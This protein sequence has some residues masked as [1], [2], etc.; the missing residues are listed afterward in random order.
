M[1]QVAKT[2]QLIEEFSPYGVPI[3]EEAIKVMVFLFLH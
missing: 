3:P 1:R 2:G